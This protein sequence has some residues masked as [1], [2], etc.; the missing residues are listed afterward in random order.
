MTKQMS[1]GVISR[2][3][4][5]TTSTKLTTQLGSPDGLDDLKYELM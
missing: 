3:A 4:S 2:L 1:P 5:I